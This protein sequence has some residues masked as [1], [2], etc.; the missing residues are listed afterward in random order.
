MDPKLSVEETVNETALEAEER[1]A[2]ERA[3]ALGFDGTLADWRS[4]VSASTLPPPPD[5]DPLPL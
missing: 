2:Y 1:D 4:R 5:N 3:V